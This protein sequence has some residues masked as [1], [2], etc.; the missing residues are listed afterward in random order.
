MTWGPLQK[1]FEEKLKKAPII[2]AGPILRR[3][4][5][6]SV[7]VWAAMKENVSVKLIIY[8]GLGGVKKVFC[9]SK[10]NSSRPIQLGDNLYVY[11]ITIYHKFES[12]KIYSYDLRVNGK[13][14]AEVMKDK[15]S[16]IVYDKYDTPSFCL[17]SNNIDNLKI[18]HGSCRKPHGGWTDALAALDIQIRKKLTHPKERPQMLIL[19]GDQIYAD[20]VATQLLLFIKIIGPIL[21]GSQNIADLPTT[22]IKDFDSNWLNPGNREEILNRI[23]FTAGSHGKN[24]LLKRVEFFMMYILVWSDELW[25]DNN[26]I[27]D[28]YKYNNLP[29][30]FHFWNNGSRKKLLAFK[31]KLKLNIRRALANIPTYMIFDD[32]EIT[33]DWFRTFSWYNNTC[34]NSKVG[35]RVITNGLAAFTIFQAWG[36]SPKRFIDRQN[37]I[38]RVLELLDIN[39]TSNTKEKDL[40]SLLIPESIPDGNSNYLYSKHIDWSFGYI[41]DVFQILFLDT[42]TSRGFTGWSTPPMLISKKGIEKQ[43]K[44][45]DDPQK[46]KLTIVVSPTPIL[47]SWGVETLVQ[48][49]FNFFGEGDFADVEAWSTN[50]VGFTLIINQLCKYKRVIILSGDVHY[51]FTIMAQKDNKDILLIQACSSSLKNSDIKTY[52]LTEEFLGTV[53]PNYENEKLKISM[54]VNSQTPIIPEYNNPNY[55]K[56]ENK[57]KNDEN[58]EKFK[59]TSYVIGADN[60]GM[61]SFVR[62][63]DK[64]EFQQ[65]FFFIKKYVWF[66]G[67]KETTFEKVFKPHTVHK[68][69]L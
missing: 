64:L 42:R 63:E 16:K 35:K 60:L 51:G 67:N 7:S 39:T 69:N 43:F 40:E 53:N 57:K 55:D 10:T 47:G 19:S 15:I 66:N 25:P 49:T 28:T 21:L 30:I 58:F 31:T 23:G 56:E 54:L 46:D 20:D 22:S 3:V 38:G 32:H 44:N 17:P 13:G 8:E 37:G 29:Y 24:H 18:A 33:D 50:E 9:E 36:N 14:L 4:D 6:Q 62:K 41:T 27:Y 68:I 1:H 59:E 48:K 45:I 11:L 65:K 34:K 5:E 61:I 52:K 26:Y 12:N 2:L